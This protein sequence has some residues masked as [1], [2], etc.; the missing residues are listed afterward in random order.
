MAYPFKIRGEYWE[1]LSEVFEYYSSINESLGV[2]FYRETDY[3]LQQIIENPEIFQ[4]RYKN[5]RQVLVRDFPYQ[6]IYEIMEKEIV[7]YT[8]FPAKANPLKR[9]K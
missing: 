7:V 2:R 9:P 4:I 8:L 1:K 5:Y 3:A 6:I